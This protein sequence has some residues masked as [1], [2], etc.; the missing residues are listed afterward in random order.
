MAHNELKVY[1][2]DISNAYMHSETN[3]QVYTTLGEEYGPFGGK[4]LVFE[5]GMYGLKTS[6]NQIP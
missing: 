6:G 3:E 5:K 1:A 2:A 4:V